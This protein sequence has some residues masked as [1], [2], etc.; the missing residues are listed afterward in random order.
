MNRKIFFTSDTHFS[1]FNVIKYAKRPFV[2]VDEMNEE[3]INR[4]NAVVTKSDF[5]YHLGDFAFEKDEAKLIWII[6]RLNGEIHLIEGNHDNKMSSKVKKQFASI[7]PFKE[8]KVV[9]PDGWGGHQ[10]VT[11]CHYALRTWNKSHFGSYS[12]FGHSHGSLPDDNNALSLDVGVDCWDFYPVEY[13]QIKERMKLK[14]F[15]PIDH[16]GD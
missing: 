1:H 7:S 2:N 8:L 3:M 9:D 11:L 16:H 5:V 14:N 13:E 6:S 10:S 15:K 4:W 12:L